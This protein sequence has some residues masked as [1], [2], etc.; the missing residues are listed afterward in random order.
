MGLKGGVST[1]S[2]SLNFKLLLGWDLAPQQPCPKLLGESGALES[3]VER[4][5]SGSSGW[6]WLTGPS[7]AAYGLGIPGSLELENQNPLSMLLSPKFRHELVRLRLH[8]GVPDLQSHVEN[9]E[10]R[11]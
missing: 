11:Q 7:V 8:L 6:V 2:R 10:A 5:A 4:R 3:R 1:Q 9:Q